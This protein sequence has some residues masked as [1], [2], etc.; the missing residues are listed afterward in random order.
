MLPDGSILLSHAKVRTWS[1]SGGV[2][3]L[4]KQVFEADIGYDELIAQG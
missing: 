1:G 4:K 3:A 2:A